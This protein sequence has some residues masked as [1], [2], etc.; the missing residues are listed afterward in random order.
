MAEQK[1]Q[2]RDFT[3]EVDAAIPEAISLAKVWFDGFNWLC[4]S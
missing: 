3:P 4:V 1:K 2:E